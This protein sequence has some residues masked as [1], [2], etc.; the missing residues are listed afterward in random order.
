MPSLIRRMHELIN[1]LPV[2][3]GL[4]DPYIV[5][6][7]CGLDRLVKGPQA[8]LLLRFGKLGN[9]KRSELLWIPVDDQ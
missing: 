7:L 4:R 1:Q 8:N 5:L 9:I 6:L 2:S 3:S